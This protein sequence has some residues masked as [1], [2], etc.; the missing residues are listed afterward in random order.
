MPRGTVVVVEVVDVVDATVVVVVVVDVVVVGG[1]VVEVADGVVV[2]V[3]VVVVV[4]IEIVAASELLAGPV[5][6]APSVTPLAASRKTTVPSLVHVTDT[7][8]EL[9]EAA[10]GVKAHPVAVPPGLLKSLDVRPETLS[11]NARV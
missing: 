8:I 4:S 11:L 1:T 6:P 10:D 5:L 3:V 7:F 2:D 9:P